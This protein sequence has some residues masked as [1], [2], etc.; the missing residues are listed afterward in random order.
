MTVIIFF[1]VVVVN[2]IGFYFIAR[3]FFRQER[4][5]GKNSVWSTVTKIFSVILNLV[6]IYGVFWGFLIGFMFMSTR[7]IFYNYH[8]IYVSDF[9]TGFLLMEASVFLPYGINM[10]LYKV[11]Y[12]KNNLCKWWIFPALLIGAVTFLLAVLCVITIG[13]IKDWSTSEW[14]R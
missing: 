1:L 7:G 12:R 5:S 13:Y 2:V 4:Y 10:F 6:L 14:I 9:F 8:K 3:N 11:W